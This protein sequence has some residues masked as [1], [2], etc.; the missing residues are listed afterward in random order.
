MRDKLE[1]IAQQLEALGQTVSTLSK[2]ELVAVTRSA[3]NMAAT[4]LRR[5]KAKLE[6]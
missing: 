1:F 5:A 2:P 6:E 3:I 4:Y